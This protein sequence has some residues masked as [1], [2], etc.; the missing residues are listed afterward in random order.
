MKYPLKFA[1]DSGSDS[2]FLETISHL[3]A[4]LTPAAVAFLR[5]NGEETFQYFE[6]GSEAK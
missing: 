5:A 4:G 2:A 1:V 6:Q 3:F